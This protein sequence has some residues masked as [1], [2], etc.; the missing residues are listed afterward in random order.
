MKRLFPAAFVALYTLAT[1]PAIGAVGEADIT[2][3]YYAGDVAALEAYRTE[4]DTDQAD[5]AVLAGYL[6]WRLGG[7]L[8]GLGETKA[9]DKALKRGQQTLTALTEREPSAEGYALLSGVIGMR[10]GISPMTRGMFMGRKVDRAAD[11]AMELAPDNPRVLLIEGIARLNAPAMFG[12]SVDEALARFTAALEAVREHGTGRYD[13][14]EADI[15]VWRG[16]AHRRND[17]LGAARTDL[18]EAIA[19]APDY[20]WARSL[21]ARLDD[22]P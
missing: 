21:R 4:L 3:A 8:L 17:D 1:G 10:I 5:D 14:G 15:L 22:E 18:D 20:S 13:W 2:T 16:L 9:A 19:I 11:R 12:G 7:L 6:D